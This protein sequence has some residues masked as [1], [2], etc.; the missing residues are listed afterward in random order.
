MPLSKGL[1]ERKN[2][3]KYDDTALMV[4][5]ESTFRMIN[6]PSVMIVSDSAQPRAGGVLVRST[7]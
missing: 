2:K 3:I 5:I 7:S 4:C 1:A 6:A